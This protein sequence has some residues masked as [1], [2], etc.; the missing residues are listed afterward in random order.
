MIVKLV[1]TKQT[2]FGKEEVFEISHFKVDDNGHYVLFYFGTNLV[3]VAQM[4]N[5]TNMKSIK[6]TLNTEFFD[7][8][9][10]TLNCYEIAMAV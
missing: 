7:K 10:A 4:S 1:E 2:L 9:R 6:Y 3:A 5:Q 8:G